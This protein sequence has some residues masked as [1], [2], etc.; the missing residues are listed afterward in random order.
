MSEFWVAVTI[1]GVITALALIVEHYVPW[2]QYL[3][4]RERLHPVG[5][6]IV[7][8]LAIYIP[9]TV[10]LLRSGGP[11][12]PPG[13]AVGALWLVTAVGGLT[14]GV[15]YGLDSWHAW[16]TRAREAELREIHAR[17]NG[18]RSQSEESRHG[19]EL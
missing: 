1:A 17:Q 18:L 4:G 7:G 15:C 13:Q 12:V 16:R 5:N 14:V 10:A 2:V 3:T 11:L 9:Y 8:M 19:G 6:Y